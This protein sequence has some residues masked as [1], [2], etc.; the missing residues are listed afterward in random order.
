VDISQNKKVQNTHRVHR[1]QKGQQTKGSS[2]EA[3]VPLGREQKAITRGR[4]GGTGRE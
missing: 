1:T 4:E 3:S 2:E